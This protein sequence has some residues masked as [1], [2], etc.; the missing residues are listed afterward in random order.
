MKLTRI[1]RKNAEKKSH[2]YG[3]GGPKG[4]PKRV[5]KGHFGHFLLGKLAYLAIKWVQKGNISDPK[6]V[7]ISAYPTSA[8]IRTLAPSV[9]WVGGWGWGWGARDYIKTG[10]V[11]VY[12]NFLT[13]SVF[14][15]SRNA[16]KKS[17]KTQ[18]TAQKAS[19]QEP[20]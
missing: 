17:I 12:I 13:G 8:H 11:K 18:K 7:P 4:G 5:K 1:S 3:P 19:I 9:G 16:E 14:L 2:F 10:C 6:M 15:R 20:I